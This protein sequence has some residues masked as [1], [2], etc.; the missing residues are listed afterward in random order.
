MTT[1]LKFQRGS[2]SENSS[3]TLSQ[4]E[5]FVDTSKNALVV[6]DGSTVGGTTLATEAF[7][8]QVGDSIIGAAPNNL[9]TLQEIAAAIDN[10]ANFA[11]TV[12]NELDNKVGFTDLSATGDLT[13]N[14]S[15]GVFSV[16]TYKSTDFD[17]DFSAKTTTDLTEGANLYYTDG[18]VDGHLSGGTGV[19]YSTGV[20]S[21]G[22]SVG[23]GDDVAFNSVS[24][25]TAPS[26]DSDATSKSY[27]D[28][29]A[30]GIITRPSA[31][32]TTTQDLNATYSAGTLTANANGAFTTDDVTGWS[33]GEEVL[34]KDQTDA[35][36]NGVYVLSVIGDASNP[37]VLDRA[38]FAD[39][40]AEIAGSFVFVTEG[41]EFANTGWVLVV[42]D[43][44]T[45]TLDTDNI[46]VNQF[47]GAGTF[48]AGAGLDLTGSEFS[49]NVG[50]GIEIAGD[51]LRLP[52]T[53][54]GNGLQLGSGILTVDLSVFSTTDLSEGSRLYYTD[55]R[56]NSAIDT[57]V[58]KAFVDAL[59]VDADTLDG[60]DS[61]FYLNYNNLNNTPVNV[62]E[63]N[64]DINYI[65]LT[66]LSASGDLIYDNTTGELSV[67]TY[68]SADFDTDFSNKTTDDLTEGT[69]QYFTGA[70]VDAYL[71][72]G[73]G[74]TYNSGEISIGQPVATT[75]SVTFDEVTATGGITF[76]T[77]LAADNTLDKYEVGTWTPEFQSV[78]QATGRSTTVFRADYTRIGN[79]VTCTFAAELG[80]LGT[81]GS[82]AFIISGLP[83]TGTGNGI[84][85]PAF[86]DNLVSPV[87]YISG[88]VQASTGRVLVSVLPAAGTG[89]DQSPEFTDYVQEGT[90][91]DG[92]V[93]YFVD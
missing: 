12:S 73:T 11:N 46:T 82:G 16:T 47:S 67:I 45:F 91:I 37:F 33:V 69:N 58:D 7:A 9:N 20:I 60:N 36:E 84:F 56:A 93:I 27:V 66:D 81:G 6:H 80:S 14:S 77:P 48:T 51:T 87:S 64:N 71:S 70:N 10:D 92:T 55:A 40:S 79:T 68:K 26:S 72:A 18:R 22:Q 62:S 75:D 17:S 38:D 85:Q 83:F 74:V 3:T 88:A 43:A 57:R 63:F 1:A 50:A 30:Q 54:A 32:A 41:T 23:T 29:V 61:N 59:D 86:F 28:S 53:L 25:G 49:V 42:D 78:N 39:E 76:T 8:N 44:A 31:R 24:L 19:A 21:I 2:T 35:T 89:M 13:Y 15:T 52:S 90:R 5:V 65:T 34:V 4:G